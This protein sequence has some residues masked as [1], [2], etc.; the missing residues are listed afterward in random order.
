MSAARK[1][2]PLRFGD[3]LRRVGVNRSCLE[4]QRGLRQGDPGEEKC[5]QERPEIIA[6]HINLIEIFLNKDEE[7]PARIGTIS[8]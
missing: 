6:S 1:T 8:T 2:R 3:Y 4:G 5:G 7:I